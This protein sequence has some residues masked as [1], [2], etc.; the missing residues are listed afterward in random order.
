MDEIEAAAA[1]ERGRRVQ[2]HGSSRLEDEPYWLDLVW[3][4]ASHALGRNGIEI[5]EFLRVGLARMILL[6]DV[7]H[8]AENDVII[9]HIEQTIDLVLQRRLRRDEQGVRGTLEPHEV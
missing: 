7:L 8:A 5:D 2:Y 4:T 3:Q 1:L 9:G 6:N